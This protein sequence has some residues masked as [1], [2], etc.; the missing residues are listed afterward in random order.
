MPL[1]AIILFAFVVLFIG[2]DEAQME[3]SQTQSTNLQQMTAQSAKQFSEFTKAAAAYIQSIGLPLS[4]TALTV[5][6][7][8]KVNLLPSSFPTQ[9]PFGQT[10]VADYVSDPNNP[11]ALDVLTHT[12]GPMN[13]ALLQKAGVDSSSISEVQYDTAVVAQNQVPSSIP[14]STGQ[15]FG[16]ED[17]STLTNLGSSDS[18]SMP[19]GISTQ[20]PEVAEYILSPGQYGY[21]LVAGS[22]YG[23]S[24]V[25]PDVEG[26]G[27]FRMF[28][29]AQPSIS[30]V[31]FSLNCP[32]IGENLSSISNNSSIGNNDTLFSSW[33]DDASQSPLFCI[34]AYKGQVIS[35]AQG[36]LTQVI[37]T[38]NDANYQYANMQW[39]GQYYVNPQYVGYYNGSN[40]SGTSSVTYVNPSSIN[41]LNENLNASGGFVSTYYP[42][43]P[44]PSNEAMPMNLPD[45]ISGA[46]I[47]ISVKDPQGNVDNYQIEMDGGVLFTGGGCWEKLINPAT[48]QYASYDVFA[49]GQSTS[50]Q[51]LCGSQETF[52]TD[53][54]AVKNSSNLNSMPVS[55]TYEANGNSYTLNYNVATPQV[56]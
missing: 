18:M 52:W 41:G 38:Q 12:T 44:T 50:D 8:Q 10:L 43:N 48:G 34:P 19:A 36:P 20:Q 17:G 46:G 2:V 16:I 56:N 24:A 55:Q 4:G 31:G 14:G 26:V 27:Q 54:H 22:V 13:P 53:W 6:D 37:N 21:W 23:W 5:S 40:S 9:T 1:I 49:T 11:V 7:L 47:D 15:F 33:N 25:W 35:F 42:N 32:S 29:F 3:T 28:M 45:N 39:N 30:S 51:N